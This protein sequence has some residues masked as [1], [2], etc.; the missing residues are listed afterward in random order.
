MF[1]PL[2]RLNKI[3]WWCLYG[4]VSIHSSERSWK[5]LL[6]ADAEHWK[7]V[8]TGASVVWNLTESLRLT[9]W[10]N[11]FFEL[12]LVPCVLVNVGSLMSTYNACQNMVQFHNC[13]ITQHSH[14][15]GVHAG[16]SSA[17]V[18]ET[19]WCFILFIFFSFF[20]SW[21][22]NNLQKLFNVKDMKMIIS[23]DCCIV[24]IAMKFGNFD[25]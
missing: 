4:I 8:P 7:G 15:R 5:V 1:R 23:F 20:V 9:V 2:A 19:S 21:G 10:W 11:F 22:Q 14:P 12:A 17:S 16:H 6:E 18:L 3:M 13:G 24:A 25:W